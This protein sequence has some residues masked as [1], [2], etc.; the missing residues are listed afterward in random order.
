MTG[1]PGEP[2]TLS[3]AA[4]HLGT[5]ANILKDLGGGATLLN[6]LTQNADDS[7]AAHLKFTATARELV[8]HNTAVFSDCG[9]QRAPVCP[10]KVAGLRAC[11]LHS[12]RKVAGREKEGGL[13]GHGRL[14]RRVHCRLPGH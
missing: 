9:D 14:R 4:D 10:W 6:E 8:V 3:R 13:H 12:F 7:R 11:D 5:L 1:T 2:V